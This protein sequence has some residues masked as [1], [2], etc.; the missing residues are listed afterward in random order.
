[1]RRPLAVHPSTPDGLIVQLAQGAVTAKPG[2]RSFGRDSASFTDAVV[3]GNGCSRS[4]PFL[5]PAVFTAPDGRTELHLRTVPPRFSGLFFMGL[6]QP[7][8]RSGRRRALRAAA[9]R[10]DAP[11]PAPVS[12]TV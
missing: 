3:Y 7:G 1:M 8:L 6:A 10:P 11:R 9:R 5:D 4:F 2:F 12:E